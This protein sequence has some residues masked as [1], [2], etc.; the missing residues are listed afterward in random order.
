MATVLNLFRLIPSDDQQ[1]FTDKCN[2]NFDQ[3]LNMGGGPPG[4]QGVTGIQ[5]VPGSQGLQGFTGAPGTPG[6]KWYVENTD[7]LSFGPVTPAPNEGDYWFDTAGLGIYNYIGSPAAWTSVGS[8]TVAGIFKD[9][10]GDTNRV[11]FTNPGPQK[12]LV[13]SPINYGFGAPQSGPYKLKLIGSPGSPMMNFGVTESGAENPAAKQSYISV[14]TVTTG[15]E[16]SWELVNPTGDIS[17]AAFGTSF[18]IIKQ[19]ATVS[20]FEFN[21][22]DFQIQINPTDRL[23]SFYGSPSNL[24]W[25]VGGHNALGTTS[26]RILSINDGGSIGI[27]DAFSNPVTGDTPYA[28]KYD[29]RNTTL[30]INAGD[31]NA[32]S[33]WRADISSSNADQLS[34][35]NVRSFYDSTTT[36]IRSSEIRLEHKTNAD[37]NHFISM[38]GGASSDT[39]SFGIFTFSNPALPSLRLGIGGTQN[40]GYYFAADSGRIASVVSYVAT[41]NTKPRLWIGEPAYIKEKTGTIFAGFIAAK[42]NIQS[43]SQG[44][45]MG[46]F[47][48]TAL[49]LNMGVGA[50]DWDH[51][52][53]TAGH[54]AT[55]QQTD[56]G[57][58]FQ[59]LNISPAGPN[60]M[61]VNLAPGDTLTGGMRT[62]FSTWSNGESY[63]WSRSNGNAWMQVQAGAVYSGTQTSST[64]QMWPNDIFAINAADWSTGAKSIIINGITQPAG[65]GEGFVGIGDRFSEYITAGPTAFTTSKWYKGTSAATHNG[66]GYNNGVPFQAANTV[67]TSGQA[68]EAKP[69]TK[70]QVYGAVTIGSRGNILNYLS[71]VGDLSFTQGINHKV[72]GLRSVVL[73]G[74]G[75]ITSAQDAV[76]IGYNGSTG[77]TNS[78]ANSIALATYTSISRGS[79]RFIRGYTIAGDIAADKTNLLSISHNITGPNGLEIEVLTPSIGSSGTI[80]VDVK[81]PVPMAVPFLITSKVNT[82]FG[83]QYN[84]MLGFNGR[85]N[86]SIGGLPFEQPV[87][88]YISSVSSSG[89]IY[90]G[91]RYATGTAAAWSSITSNLDWWSGS[92][93]TAGS[94]S[95]AVISIRNPNGSIVF[96]N[97]A[98]NS[99]TSNLRTP[100]ISHANF[101]ISSP[102]GLTWYATG[103][104]L[105]IFGGILHNKSTSN[106]VTTH[107]SDVVIL[108][109]EAYVPGLTTGTAANV[110]GGDVYVSGGRATYNNTGSTGTEGDVILAYDPYGNRE[111]GRVVI[112]NDIVTGLPATG[113]IDTPS[114]WIN[115]PLTSGGAF[116]DIIYYD[117]NGNN[118]SW[119][120][121]GSYPNNKISY[122]VIGRTCHIAF[123]V[124][125]SFTDS[126][127]N[128]THAMGW[129]L[130]T[131]L[132]PNIN[133]FNFGGGRATYTGS[134][135]AP[136][137][138]ITYATILSGNA[139][140]RVGSG[141]AVMNGPCILLEDYQGSPLAA[142]TWRFTGY[143]TYEIAYTAPGTP[144][145]GF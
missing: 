133:S 46:T 135:E 139:N 26:D 102:P 114:G 13:I 64:V 27:N 36:T 104:K 70:F 77:V 7:P 16:Y 44:N 5:G 134:G 3:I 24:T 40:D 14:N 6:S 143:L 94:T 49:H 121:N 37:F 12:S 129:R 120:F 50:G 126:N 8:L 22:N 76:T 112:H 127:L 63:F 140:W 137:V 30:G 92:A 69:Q 35:R 74:S 61:A 75:H 84:N 115:V 17:F 81:A 141:S 11:I 142:N 80:P 107:A 100:H 20:K 119:S 83:F 106:L 53:I 19:N 87:G 145:D 124:T 57:V 136:R 18:D 42:L 105:G 54:R 59:N 138:L 51:V 4:I 71:D 95:S 116:N 48:H 103:N 132:T 123:D 99:A 32:W 79:T 10:P 111:Q 21:N 98:P 125:G 89:N 113:G 82:G 101:T 68:V 39:T 90:T 67:L 117:P 43:I 66:I 31:T 28:Y 2:F 118:G 1:L 108:G 130:P 128:Y 131:H 55:P 73:G 52:G 60:M 144:P 96:K 56:A 86:L 33:R 85:S 93:D 78:T 122:K 110:L 88:V 45:A 47:G 25:H 65:F 97:A 15:S 91:T 29:Q 109:G 38:G 72:S 34:V 41:F 9:A 62:L 23:M 58:L